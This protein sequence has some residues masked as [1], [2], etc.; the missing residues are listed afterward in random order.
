MNNNLYPTIN[1]ISHSN[2]VVRC[3]GTLQ[4]VNLTTALTKNNIKTMG[5]KKLYHL[6]RSE[7]LLCA[8][9]SLSSDTT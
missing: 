3:T 4:S 5:K 2:T 6:E 7:K 1:N 9:I 8:Y